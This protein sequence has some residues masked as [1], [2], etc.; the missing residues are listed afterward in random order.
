MK[1]AG[2]CILHYGEVY[3]SYTIKSI[4]NIVDEIVIVYTPFP[5]F[6]YNT[7]LVCPDKKE[8]LHL[9]TCLEDK[10]KKITWIEK[11]FKNQSEH[12]AFA[13]NLCKQKG[14]DIIVVFDSDEIYDNPDYLIEAVNYS[15][16]NN[17]SLQ[18]RMRHFYRS[19]NEI[20]TDYQRQNRILNINMPN[21]FV[22]YDKDIMIDHFGY[23]QPEDIITYKIA[24]HGDQSEFRKDFNWLEDKF[25]KYKQGVT[26]DCHPVIK[27]MWNPEPFTKTLLPEILHEHPFFNFE[28][29]A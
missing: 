5:S 11:S 13:Y 26:K 23:A 21:Q 17:V 27:D 22:L 4:Y 24:I 2:L 19:F 12:R 20:C 15:Y 16:K 3:L 14:A 18:I 28:K 29:I 8:N 7:S 9:L 25:L 1:T 6:S 10:A